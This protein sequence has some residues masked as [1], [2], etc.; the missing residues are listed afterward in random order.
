MGSITAH[1]PRFAEM[2]AWANRVLLVDLSEGTIRARETAPWLPDW[3]GGR[4]LTARAAWELAPEPVPALDPANPLMVFAGALTGSRAAYSG[5]ATVAAFSPQGWPREWFKRSSI[6]AHFGGELKRAG[7]DGIVVTGASETPV[8]ILIR[9]DEVSILPADELWGMEVIDALDALEADAG[10]GAHSLVIG[11]AGENLSAIATIQTASSSAAGHGGLGAVMGSK[12]LKAITVVGTGRV[13]L[14]DEDRIRALSRAL[15]KEHGGVMSARREQIAKLNEQLEEQGG[16][17]VRLYACTEAC[18]TPCNVYYQGIQGV[19]HDRTYSGHWA[20]VG[21]LLRGVR[22]E[23]GLDR[24][25]IFDWHL[26]MRGAFEI[27]VLS[28]TYGINQWDL[29]VGMVPWLEACQN[30]GLLGKIN[31]VPMDWD[32]PEFWAMLVHAIAYREGFGD[33]LAKGGWAAA[34]SLDLGVDLMRRYYTGWGHAGHWDGHGDFANYVVFPYWIASV[35]QWMTDTRD[36]IPSGHGHASRFMSYIPMRAG[37]MT[38]EQERARLAQI[39]GI[40]EWLYGDH[41][42]LD[43]RGGYEGKA[44]AAAFHVVRSMMKDSL[45]SDDYVMPLV[46]S[47]HSEDGIPRILGIEGRDVEAAFFRAGTGVDWDAAAF[48]RANLNAFALERALQV[49]HFGR[50]RRMDESVLPYFAYPENWANRFVG[51]R[52][53]LDLIQFETVASE[54]YQRLDWDA[55]TGRPTEDAMQATGIEDAYGDMVA[56]AAQSEPGELPEEPPITYMT[57]EAVKEAGAA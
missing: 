17:H 44:A 22:S 13:S 30:T 48:E 41:R 18:P 51:E 8:R 14:A 9:D 7:Y 31:G 55:A 47:P 19:A 42:A 28:N 38:P 50:D 57:E 12:K 43:P 20:C 11:P 10:R 5:R 53:A 1:V 40:A 37:R 25:G 2:D 54:Y 4:A 29:L 56:G 46:A 21:G 52:R 32:S 6:G 15:A 45:P 35:L 23:P 39:P 34:R 27:N 49:R 33:V 16:G 26:G 36:P 3:I 24:R